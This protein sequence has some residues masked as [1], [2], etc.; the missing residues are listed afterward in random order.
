MD[1]VP[2][3]I[4]ELRKEADSHRIERDRLQKEADTLAEEKRVLSSKASKLESEAKHS[5]KIAADDAISARE[6]ALMKDQWQAKLDLLMSRGGLGDIDGTRY[7]IRRY[8]QTQE[9]LER[10]VAAAEKEISSKR[11]KAEE[12]RKRSA[13]AG[14]ES[15]SLRKR[16]QAEHDAY[17]SVMRRIQLLLEHDDSQ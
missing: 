1:D 11:K 17:I 14:S 13:K 8:S 6:A 4:A 5:E 2:S 16:S 10:S 7:Q 3:R 15:S 9:R 12:L